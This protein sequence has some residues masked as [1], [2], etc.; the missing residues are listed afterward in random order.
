MFPSPK[1]KLSRVASMSTPSANVNLTTGF[2]S[3]G[4]TSLNEAGFSFVEDQIRSGTGEATNFW[5]TPEDSTLAGPLA[6]AVDVLDL[7]PTGTEWPTVGVAVGVYGGTAAVVAFHDV[8][9][10]VATVV[11]LALFGCW[12]LSLQHECLHGHPFASKR[13]NHL[14]AWP[15][16]S[17]WLP[18]A[19][20][21]ES[22]L[23]HHRNAMLTEPGIDPESNYFK[24]SVWA[25]LA[26]LQQLVFRGNQTLLGRM[27]FRPVQGVWRTALAIPEELRSARWR[28]TWAAQA[29]GSVL[30]LVVLRQSAHLPL[31]QYL[32]GFVYGGASLAAVRAYA[33]HQWAGG[34]KARSAT[35]HAS[36]FWRLLF[37]NNNYH[38]AH[39]LRP[40][41]SWFKVPELSARVQADV[42][43]GEGAG[44]YSGY[45]EVFKRFLLKPVIPM[46]H[47]AYPSSPCCR[48]APNCNC[49]RDLV[50]P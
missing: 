16:L 32:L 22:H 9:G 47:P 49:G 7:R 12:F 43:S 11:M 10:P 35:V 2:T 46:V 20:Y 21:R 5:C 23:T 31:W 39:H 8:L 34:T 42:L 30:L 26:P 19:V 45:G 29:L 3:E 36:M 27:V 24:G 38:Y 18:F 1:E 37:L 40:S 15:P 14:V 50:F 33:E 41:L 17:I 6:S 28:K 25:A 4:S 48:S 13:L 44:F